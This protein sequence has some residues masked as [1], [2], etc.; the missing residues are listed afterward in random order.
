[1]NNDPE[2]VVKSQINFNYQ[3]G[4]RKINK[5]LNEIFTKFENIK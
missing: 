3:L 2:I 1:M 4:K 5:S